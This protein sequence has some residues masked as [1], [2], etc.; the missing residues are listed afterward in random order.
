MRRS[1]ARPGPSSAG[2]AARLALPCLVLSLSVS[3]CGRSGRNP[4]SCPS[5][6][7]GVP[8]ASSRGPGEWAAHHLTPNLEEQWRAGGL[9]KGQ[10]LAMP[11]GAAPGLHGRLAIPDF[12]LQRV[13]V[14]DADGSWAGAWGRKGDGPGEYRYPLAAAWSRTGR[15]AV[16]DVGGGRVVFFRKGSAAG[17]PLRTAPELLARL[18]AGGRLRWQGIGPDGTLFLVPPADTGVPATGSATTGGEGPTVGAVLLRVAP[19]ASSPDTLLKATERVLGGQFPT[20]PAP[21]WPRLVAAVDPHGGV[22]AAGWGPGFRIAQFDTDGSLVRIVCRVAPPMPFTDAE[23][24]GSRPAPNAHLAA[25]LR[26]SPAPAS[27]AAVARLFVGAEG[28]IWAE[29][30]RPR[31]LDRA[32][33]SFGR[34]GGTFDVFGPEGRYLGVVR[35]PDSARLVAA[36]GERVWGFVEGSLDQTTVVAY[37]LTLEKG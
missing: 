16:L 29:R 33:A 1:R 18:V 12:Q 25:A 8:V 15:L 37:R 23:R 31:A 10:T 11:I 32:D 6:S 7:A 17:A 19:G 4:P 26:K 24:G 14:L 5:D 28:R 20:W 9:R 30:D 27:P 34:P 2:A 22:V 35:A 3:A 36:S 21:G 13:F